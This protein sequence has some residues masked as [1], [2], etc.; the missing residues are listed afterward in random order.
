M[1]IYQ[2]TYN[3]ITV[4]YWLA[5]I[6]WVYIICC[7]SYFFILT[8][9]DRDEGHKPKHVSLTVKRFDILPY[10]SVAGLFTSTQDAFRHGIMCRSPT[11]NTG[12]QSPTH[13]HCSYVSKP[14][15]TKL[16]GS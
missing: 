2:H 15:K 14:G 9:D 4:P 6:L 16:E 5:D 7:L 11:L 8:N 1:T 10:T 3:N 13:N 12:A